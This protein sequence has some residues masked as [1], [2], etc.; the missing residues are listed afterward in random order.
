MSFMVRDIRIHNSRICSPWIFLPK[1]DDR[2]WNYWVVEVGYRSPESGVATEQL[3]PL[4]RP[5]EINYDTETTIYF[6][7][8]TVDNETGTL[9]GV[10]ANSAGE[11]YNP[12]PEEEIQIFVVHINRFEQEN[13]SVQ[14]L[15]DYNNI[16]QF[17]CL[18]HRRQG[19]AAWPGEA[20]RCGR[21][22]GGMD[23]RRPGD[24]I[25]TGPVSNQDPSDQ[26]GHHPGRCRDLLS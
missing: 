2:E 4:L 1:Q 6:A 5:A 8:G 11:P 24:S 13:F 20:A 16:S 14:L 25:S 10:Y 23:E 26:L 3:N 17:G 7:P 21:Q 19:G 18:H 15:H 12:P 22:D 9:T